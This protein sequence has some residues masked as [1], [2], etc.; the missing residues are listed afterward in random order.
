MTVEAFMNSSPPKE[1]ASPMRPQ[2]LLL[3]LSCI[4]LASCQSFKVD[5]QSPEPI[6][7]DVNMRLDVYQYKGDEP[8][9]PDAAQASYDA[10]QTRLRNRYAEIQTFKNN[11]L[12]GEDHRGLLHL[13]EK[14]AGEWGD[15]VEKQVNQE[16]ED[17]TILIR[18]LAKDSDRAMHEVQDEQWKQRT[19]KAYHGE[20]IEVPGDKQNTFKWVQSNGPRQKPASNTAGD[21]SK[22]PGT[23]SPAPG[24]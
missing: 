1:G 7:V 14:P 18:R 5:L 16:N 2:R 6:K 10:A 8:D 22:P 3:A 24:T 20:W 9:K 19:S 15:Y 13:R 23:V 11:G 4:A 17:R 21:N 12:V